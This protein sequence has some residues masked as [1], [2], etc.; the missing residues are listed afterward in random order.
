MVM[1]TV[2]TIFA[3]NCYAVLEGLAI[4]AGIH[5]TLLVDLPKSDGS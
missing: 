1:V 4:P 2:L 5:Q 3:W